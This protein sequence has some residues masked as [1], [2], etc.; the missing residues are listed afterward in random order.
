M[1]IEGI[2]YIDDGWAVSLKLAQECAELI[3]ESL[4]SPGLKK[5]MPELS[6][7]KFI[8]ELSEDG[9]T[10]Y[11]LWR[12]ISIDPHYRRP[13]GWDCKT[14]ITDCEKAGKR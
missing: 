4:L 6:E 10:G 1:V 13:C 14:C 12:R 9:I 5:A 3:K 7:Y 2:I 11:R 8:P